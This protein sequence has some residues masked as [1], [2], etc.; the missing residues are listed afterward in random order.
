MSY[1]KRVQNITQACKKKSENI[2]SSNLYNELGK[3]YFFLL[4]NYR[5]QRNV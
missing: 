1:T 2:I 3:F 4:K 5:R